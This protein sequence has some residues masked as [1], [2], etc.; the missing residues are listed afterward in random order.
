MIIISYVFD[1]DKPIYLQL[2]EIIKKEIFK[3]ELLPSSK[4]PSVRDFALKY[5]VNPNT[6][7]KALVEL[8]NE[9]L[10]YTERTNG[11]YVT[12]DEKKL[13]K[14]KKQLAQEK[15]NN[16]LNSMKSIG[17]NYEDA[18]SYLQE[19]GGKDGNN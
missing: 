12:E 3:C 18:L 9:K 8:E 2:E 13:E 4:I 6:M 17:I 1:N 14:T 16:Y 7:Q 5:Q 11:K 19:L 15:V 10:I